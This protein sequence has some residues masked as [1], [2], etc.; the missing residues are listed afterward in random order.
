MA[1]PS[2]TSASRVLPYAAYAESLGSRYHVPPALVLAVIHMESGGDPDAFR[3]EPAVRDAS[4]GLMQVLLGTARGKGFA[5]APR[6]LFDPP[7]SIELGT[8]Y[9]AEGI[10]E[11]GSPYLALIKYNGGSGAV[12][13]YRLGWRLG[14]AVHYANLVYNTLRPYFERR[15]ADLHAQAGR[16]G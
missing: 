3:V 16:P 4:F 7:V 2:P 10:A 11:T 6:Y 12:R 5:Q 13:A 8:R 1:D 14:P 9:L 15:L